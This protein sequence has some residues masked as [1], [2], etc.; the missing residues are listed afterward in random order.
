M[1][2]E[3]PAR[4]GRTDPNRRT[5]NY[6]MEEFTLTLMDQKGLPLYRLAGTHMVHYPDND[7]VEVTAPHAVFYRQDTP[8]WEV[9]AEQGLTNS[10]GDEI[11]LLG[12]VVIRQFGADAKTNKMKIFTQDM[13]VEPWA[14]YAETNQPI[15]LLNSFGKTH[16]IGAQVYLK[17]ER[18]ELLSQ[19]R[20]DY[21]PTPRP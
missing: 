17:E 2:N 13:R 6:F 16:A 3:D 18:I 10:Q 7:T 19:V 4:P 11:Y 21:E 14:K 8:H 15:T 9:V 12:E 5:A 1:L 20:G